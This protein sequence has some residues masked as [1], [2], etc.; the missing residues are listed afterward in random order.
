MLSDITFTAASI[1][2]KGLLAA[3]FHVEK[4]PG[5]GHK[6]ECLAGVKPQS[7]QQPSA[8]PWFNLQAAQMPTQDIAI[9]GGGIASLCTTL[10]LLQRGASVTLYCADDAPALNASGNKQ[11]AFYPQLSDDN[12]ANIR[13]YLH[14]FSY[15]GQLLHWLLKQGIEF[16]HAFCG[17]ALSGYN[18]KAEE[19]L[20]KIAELHLPSAIYQPMEQT[21][22]SAAVGLPLP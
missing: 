19:K 1:V 13:F 18:A 7:I 22:L 8:T 3:G 21:Q 12:A 10:A 6:R 2:R 5:F 17:V 11:G 20:R 14:A 4:R 9:V 16:E 15:G